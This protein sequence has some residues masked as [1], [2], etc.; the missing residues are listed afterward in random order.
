MS[1]QI[2][3]TQGKFAI[4]D[5]EDYP[6]LNRFRWYASEYKGTERA[7]LRIRSLNNTNK[8][9]KALKKCTIYI[10][11]FLLTA[12]NGYVYIHLNK[13]GL[14]VRKENLILS[15]IPHAY[16]RGKKRKNTTSKYKGVYFN[17]RK[18]EKKWCAQV[19]KDKKHYLVGYFYTEDEAGE[20][21]NEK[22]R[23]LYGEIAFQNKIE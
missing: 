16:Q 20:A 12:R 19:S 13:N 3:L 10:E 4:V 2:K 8:T 11:Q 6:Y 7:Q 5:D 1:K 18:S 23:E 21:Y 22:A 15:T 17:K 9:S 14:D